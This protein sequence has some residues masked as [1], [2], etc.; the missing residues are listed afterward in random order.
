MGAAFS[1]PKALD[2]HTQACYGFNT[3]N[4]IPLL[5][6]STTVQEVIYEPDKD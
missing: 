2:K 3:F 6:T 4:N 1:Q 5:G